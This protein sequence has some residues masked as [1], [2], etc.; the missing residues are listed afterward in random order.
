MVSLVVV[1]AD[2]ATDA[3]AAPRLPDRGLQSALEFA[4]GIAAAGAKLRPPLASPAGLKPYLRFHKL[5]P[6]ALA[7]VREAPLGEGAVA[8]ILSGNARR[9]IG[10]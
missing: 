2:D 4:V 10:A 8:A 1:S 9:L 6:T 7:K 3:A 5:P